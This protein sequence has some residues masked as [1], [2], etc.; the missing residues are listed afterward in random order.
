[1]VEML[2]K[3]LNNRLLSDIALADFSKVFDSI[4][5]RILSSLII[6]DDVRSTYIVIYILL[7]TVSRLAHLSR[8][9]QHDNFV[10]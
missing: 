1:M 9:A 3:S 7:I 2:K 4:A 5:C 6:P 10:M 8:D